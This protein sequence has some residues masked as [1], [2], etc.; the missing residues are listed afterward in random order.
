[1]VLCGGTGVYGVSNK[2]VTNVRPYGLTELCSL[3]FW[4][5][6]KIAVMGKG[7]ERISELVL[8]DHEITSSCPKYQ[9][10]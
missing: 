3:S 4:S 9:C 10:F 7:N 8:S 5:P 1:M 2:A 6:H